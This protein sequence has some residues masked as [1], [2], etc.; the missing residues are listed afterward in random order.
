MTVRYIIFDEIF[1]IKNQKGAMNCVTKNIEM[2]SDFMGDFNS[3]MGTWFV[4]I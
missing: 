4:R 1:T 3:N 2:R